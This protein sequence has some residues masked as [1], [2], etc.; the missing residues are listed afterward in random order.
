MTVP[1]LRVDDLTVRY[2]QRAAVED[3]SFRVEAGEVVAVVGP[4]R[5]RE[6]LAAAGAVR[7]ADRERIGRPARPPL[8]PRRGA[9]RG[10]VRAAAADRSDRG[11]DDRR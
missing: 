10:G 3:V 7:P 4:E 1:L 5:G 8:P 2:G 6:V 11:A 9:G